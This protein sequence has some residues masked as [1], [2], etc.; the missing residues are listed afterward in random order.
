MLDKSIFLVYYK[1]TEEK[2]K[3]KQIWLIYERG[4]SSEHGR[5]TKKFN[6]PPYVAK[7]KELSFTDK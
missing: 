6:G 1:D 4:E 2:E 7:L 3:N 5:W